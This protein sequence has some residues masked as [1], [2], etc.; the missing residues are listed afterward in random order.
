MEV[1]Q[2]SFSTQKKVH[3]GNYSFHPPLSLPGDS[4]GYGLL[5]VAAAPHYFGINKT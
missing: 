3:E 1:S 5:T 4:R 2:A